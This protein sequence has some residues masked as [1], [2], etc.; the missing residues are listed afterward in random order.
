MCV[1][2]CFCGYVRIF[3]L[4]KVL[5]DK[6]KK[7]KIHDLTRTIIK[8]KMRRYKKKYIVNARM[9]LLLSLVAVYAM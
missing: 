5:K 7:R 8:K 4:N 9:V 6:K 3:K 1:W 2:V